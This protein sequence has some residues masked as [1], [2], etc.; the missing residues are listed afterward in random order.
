MKF[1]ALEKS[2]SEA[3]AEAPLPLLREEA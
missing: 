3:S 2:L 1:L